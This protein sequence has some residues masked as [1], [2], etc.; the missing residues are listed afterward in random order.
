MEPATTRAAPRPLRADAQRNR[1]R[2][3]E[4]AVELLPQEGPHLPLEAVA[5]RARV[6][7]ATLYRHFP[8]RETLV[9]AV[10][11]QE[12]TELATWADE[13]AT[14]LPA[15]VALQRWLYHLGRYGST[16]PG[17]GDAFR[18]A[19]LAGEELLE[20]TYKATVDALD[21]LIAGAAAT[22]HARSDIEAGDVLLALCGVWDLPGTPEANAQTD[23]VV[24][25]LLDGL[26]SAR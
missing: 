12:M 13:L 8:T 17:L 16:R 15:E 22:G 23:R 14:T 7:I 4:A 11:H 20:Q 18:A 3:L 2:L 10:H 24:R 26:A 9:L 1:D 5:R 19:A 21:G 6:S 25:L